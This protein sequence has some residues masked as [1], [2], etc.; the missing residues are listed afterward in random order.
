MRESLWPGWLCFGDVMVL[1]D[2]WLLTSRRGNGGKDKIYTPPPWERSQ[3]R[4]RERASAAA[5]PLLPPGP[6]PGHR[7]KALQQRPRSLEQTLL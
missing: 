3:L 2:R 5:G 7:V 6:P 1:G 4:H